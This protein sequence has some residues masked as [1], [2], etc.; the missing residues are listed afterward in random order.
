MMKIVV[1]LVD[2]CTGTLHNYNVGGAE[3][4]VN[5]LQIKRESLPNWLGYKAMETE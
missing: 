4:V 1:Y 5:V 3:I 2:D